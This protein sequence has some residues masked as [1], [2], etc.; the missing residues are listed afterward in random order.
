LAR[1]QPEDIVMPLPSAPH[2]VRASSDLFVVFDA[3][4][5]AFDAALSEGWHL[6]EETRRSRERPQLEPCSAYRHRGSRLDAVPEGIA[7]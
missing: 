5:N 1:S 2:L 7:A 3:D 6:P 4:L